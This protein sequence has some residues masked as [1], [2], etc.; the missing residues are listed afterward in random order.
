VK[1]ALL[2]AASF[3]AVAGTWLAFRRLANRGVTGDL[4]A[5]AAFGAYIEFATAPLWDYHYRITVYKDT[6]LA[7]VLGWGVMFT[8]VVY[9]SEKMYCLVL[10]KESVPM[11]DKRILLFDVAGAVLIGLPIEWLGLRLGI[12]SYR[13]DLLGWDWGS[14]PLFGM[15]LEALFGYALL[16]FAAPTFVRCW[17]GPFAGRAPRLRPARE[18]PAASHSAQG[19]QGRQWKRTHSQVT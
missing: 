2:E 12:W 6:P 18:A 14:I 9:L 3:A 15:P 19:R 11:F 8:V 17:E 16:M 5:G 4:A 10:R 7:V 13:H 1:L